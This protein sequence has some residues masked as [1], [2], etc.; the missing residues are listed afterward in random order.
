M[1]N[2]VR[3]ND[4]ILF[5]PLL[6]PSGTTSIALETSLTL[7]NSDASTDGGFGRDVTWNA[8]VERS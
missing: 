4:F 2:N 7:L 1:R 3:H 8:P 5:L 6:L